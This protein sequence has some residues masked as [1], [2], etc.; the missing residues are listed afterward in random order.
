MAGSLASKLLAAIA[1][2]GTVIGAP[3]GD[4]QIVFKADA[5]LTRVHEEYINP[6]QTSP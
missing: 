1:I 3:I 6:C 4:D 2:G 5:D